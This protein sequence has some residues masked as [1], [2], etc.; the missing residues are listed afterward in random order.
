MK[1]YCIVSVSNF[2]K[3]KIKKKNFFHILNKNNLNL[4]RLNVIN[5]DIIFVP[6]WH[7]KIEKNIFNKYKTIIFHSTPLPFGRGGSPIQNM[8]L[9]GFLST[10]ICAIEAKEEL[11]SGNIFLKRNLSLEGSAN[12]IYVRMYKII[13]SM[14]KSLT[15]KKLPKPKEQKGKIIFFKRRK[16]EDSLVDFSSFKLN[17]IYNYIRMLDLDYKK[18]P[19]AFA[20]IGSYKLI[21]SKAKKINKNILECSL[22]I[23]S[24]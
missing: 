15:L 20:T 2:F 5:P 6:H 8:I 1:K 10:E 9:K 17:E 16:K 21:F 4:K 12:E 14:I 3:K 23:S 7:W 22:R 13:L 19:K 11:D 18:F 24:K